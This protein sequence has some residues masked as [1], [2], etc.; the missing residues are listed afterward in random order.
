LEDRV[1][2]GIDVAC[3][4]QHQAS[5]AD[6]SGSF[7]WSG[8]RFRTSSAELETL[9]SK[10][11]PQHEVQVVIEPTG[12]SWVPLAVWLKRQ[13][14]KVALVPPEQSSDLR[15]YY[16]K[17]SKTDRLD[18]RVLARL[19]L[20]HP[21]GLRPIDSLGTADPLR[22]AVRRRSTLKRQ[23]SATLLRISS[24]L[25]LMGPA[26]AEAL[27]SPGLGQAALAVLERYADP[28]ALRQI[29]RAR[30][31]K[32]LI[33]HSRGA[34]RESKADQLREAALDAIRLWRDPD[35]NFQIDFAQLASDISSEVRMIRT[36]D[37]EIDELDVRIEAL[38]LR[39]DPAGVVSST[40]GIG[41]ITAAAILGRTG[42]F[43]RFEN[44]SGVRAFTGLVPKVDQSG[45]SERHGG[46]TKAGDPGLR[47]AVFIAADHARK[48]DPTL[49]AR[50]YRLMIHEGKHHNSA[51]CTIAATLITRIAACWRNG[52][53]YEI[54]DIDGTLIT[55][56]EGRRIC[57]ERY[58]I[59]PEIR[60]ARRQA[61][62]A[63]KLKMGTG[64][65]KKESTEAAPV[66]G[67]SIKKAS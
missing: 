11:P 45:L 63:K 58:A 51:L 33:Q 32:L 67:P 23:R 8:W 60:A 16:N 28:M 2:L 22:R 52:Q 37:Q 66:L 21:E 46:P 18:S 59:T 31:T 62:R 15:K 12:N 24:L 34:W 29:G 14:A 49:A 43:N 36:L 1:L 41:V 9:W 40:P 25:E 6:S 57:A 47:E 30:L 42:D 19:P 61:K 27:V 64:R 54:R 20:L 50:Y 17:H 65:H 39:A 13:G 4:S 44:L 48:V 53:T 7:L 3:K 56:A 38:Y 35:L 5:C 10:L 55:E 26:L